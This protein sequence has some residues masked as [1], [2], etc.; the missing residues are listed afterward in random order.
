MPKRKTPRLKQLFPRSFNFPQAAFGRLFR[1]RV[2]LL[3]PAV[4]LGAMPPAI[5]AERLNPFPRTK[6]LEFIEP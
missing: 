5:R 6:L 3:R 2:S 4:R 1:F